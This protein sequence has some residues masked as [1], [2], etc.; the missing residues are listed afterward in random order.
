MGGRSQSFRL[1]RHK[2]AFVILNEMEPDDA[3]WPAPGIP[4]L[5]VAVPVVAQLSVPVGGVLS[6]RA[7]TPTINASAATP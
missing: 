2:P 7:D 1:L 5:S 4:G 3:A 6:A